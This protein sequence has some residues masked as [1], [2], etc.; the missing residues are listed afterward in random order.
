[1]VGGPFHMQTASPTS[2]RIR[3]T[4]KSIFKA[5]ICEPIDKR[6]IRLSVK[7][8]I[9]SKVRW[10]IRLSEL[11]SNAMWTGDSSLLTSQIHVNGC[12]SKKQKGA[13]VRSSNDLTNI[14]NISVWLIPSPRYQ[15]DAL[16]RFKC[17]IVWERG[18]VV[19]AG[20]AA[21]WRTPHR[22]YHNYSLIINIFGII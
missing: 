12:R 16:S 20:R 1:M 6:T 15:R 11:R 13:D 7:C 9:K 14:S 2:K 8:T 17:H 5:C 4:I 21:R 22:F 3:V 10:R 18:V 19:G